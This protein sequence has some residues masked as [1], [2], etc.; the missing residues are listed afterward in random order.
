[1]KLLALHFYIAI[2]C[3][4][5]PL[6]TK[7][8][9]QVIANPVLPGV[10]DA[11][12][13]KF[14]G[15]YY[16]GGV[17]TNGGFY[18]SHD[19]VKW[20]GPVHVF[21][22]DNN[23]TQGPS[24]G[25]N[26]IHANDINYVNGIFHLYWSVNYWGRDGNT[27]HI[28]HA[29]SK[30]ILGPYKE[31]V[32][33]TW[34]DNRIDPEMFIDDDGKGYLYMVKF[35]DGNAIWVRPMK[36]PGT[37]SGEPKYVFSSLPNTWETLDNRVE[38]GP[39]VIKYRNKYYMMYNANHTSPNWGNYALGVAEANGPL[40]FNHGNKYPYPVVK[41]NQVDVEDNN[42]DLLKYAS[43][44]QGNFRYTNDQPAENWNQINFDA[45]LWQ[46]G[47]G[48]FGSDIIRGSTTRKIATAWKADGIW[49]RSAFVY[50]KQ[51][52]GNLM[53]RI[54]HDGATNVFLNG[55]LIYESNNRNYSTW[56]FDE[57]A[58]SLLRDGENVLAINSQKGRNT[59]YLD[60]ALFDMKDK[61][62]D[63]ILFS[64][65]QPNIVK[66]PNGFEWWLVYMANKNAERRGQ[67]INRVHFFDK[68]LFVDG[69]TSSNTSGYHPTPAKP[70]FNE[71]FNDNGNSQWQNKWY[72]KTGDWHIQNKELIQSSG[73][74]S[75]AIIN[76][77]AAT[78][79]LF[80]AGIKMTSPQTVKAGVYAWWKDDNNW[81]KVL[82]NKSKKTW[83]Y[84]LRKD[85]KTTTQSFA[86][87]SDFDYTVYHTLSV[88][89]N[90]FNFTIKIDDLPAPGNAVIKTSIS[91]KGIP[92]LYTEGAAAFDGILYTIGWDEFA[93]TITGWGAS[94]K[95]KKQKGL[96]SVT[97]EGL[98]QS[99]E[100]G[101]NFVFKGD[102]LD[103]Y[104]FN[105]Q[106]TSESNKGSAGVYAVYADDNNYLKAVFDFNH[107]KFIVSGKENGKP[108]IA[109]EVSLATS[110]S[111]YANMAN[112][113][114][115]EKHF[116]FPVPTF[117][118]GLKLSKMPYPRIDTLLQNIQEKVNVFYKSEGKWQQ[119]TY[120]KE[121]SPH[122]AFEKISFDTILT[123]EL[124]FVNKEAG[125]QNF[126]IYKI[127]AD[128][129]IKQSYNLRVVKL[130]DAV[131]F[132]VDGKELYR[133]KKNFPAA[134]IG[135]VTGNCKANFN[136]I[137]HFHLQEGK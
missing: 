69:I 133:M 128:A 80:E 55:S 73:K 88:Y 43:K 20:E 30:N 23:W 37:F 90:T 84:L 24:A 104:E 17:S 129:L 78:N 32:K 87:S 1:M 48:G 137:T 21:S 120:K 13:I 33:D 130:K 10:A 94:Y 41:S 136:G 96:W 100:A 121:Q 8:Q 15:E 127:W 46:K 61:K 25:D 75:H 12:V 14:N 108:I 22:M 125:D 105:A 124:K 64:P 26:Q 111:N 77:L 86:L 65:G 31:P 131:I 18:I 103:E 135:F 101:E 47:K 109:N 11:G 74:A 114:F 5:F 106:V 98:T 56:N 116:S 112:T 9:Q 60:V 97:K 81:V 113:D 85:G 134:Q 2:T 117:I 54:N 28:G 42:V 122:P 99:S 76:S 119:V 63:D 107:Q 66:G 132:F 36:D 70:T 52:N 7:G 19:L 123:D 79:Y 68:R 29:T 16:I 89:K 95:D 39:W 83:L 92:G 59:N 50:D 102:A 6:I 35:T 51:S 38:E 115:F 57:K 3:I 118:N 4:S 45:S 49:M 34:L 91:G 62:G 71:L 58:A 72:I 40:E 93:T 82:L 53:L 27:I 110:E 126:Y 44:D 67:Y